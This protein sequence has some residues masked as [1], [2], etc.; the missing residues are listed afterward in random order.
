ML[1]LS[2]NAPRPLKY[3]IDLAR[4]VTRLRAIGVLVLG[5]GNVVH[6][7]RLLDRQPA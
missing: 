2:H 7:L 6:N 1:Q 4:K 3:H 5:S